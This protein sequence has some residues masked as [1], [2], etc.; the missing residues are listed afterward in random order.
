MIDEIDKQILKIL[1]QNARTPNAE[2]ARQVGLVPSAIL[3]RI[4]KLEERGVIQGYGVRL[5]GRALGLGLLAFVLVRTDELAGES[6]AASA[7]C[8]MPE[9][10]EVH[11]IAGEDC[12]LVKVRTADTESLGRLLR[13]QIG[14]IESVRSTR[15]TIVLHTTKETEAISLQEVFQ[16]GE[17]D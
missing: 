9:V 11:H 15:T 3:E 5:N 14:A 13:E 10:L 12:F 16:E 17:G 2:I 7:L 8:V 6:V 4:R 1:Q